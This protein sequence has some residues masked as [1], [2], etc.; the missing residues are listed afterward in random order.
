VGRKK[1]FFFARIPRPYDLEDLLRTSTEVLGKGTYGTRYKAAIESG[2]V[3]A[4]KRLKET[5]LPE[6]EF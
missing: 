3:M 2:L 4:V 1:L 5:S 6:C